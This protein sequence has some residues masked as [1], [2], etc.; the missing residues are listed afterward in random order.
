VD[1]V[2]PEVARPGAVVS[3]LGV[4]LDRA[5]VLELILSSSD[6]T[7]LVHVVEQR[8][9]FIRFEVPRSPSATRYSIVLMIADDGGPELV[10]QLVY[11]TIRTDVEDLP[12]TR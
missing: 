9:N 8:E 4:N 12:E 7:M 3:A 10:D 6:S 11:I 1:R 5:H 2:E